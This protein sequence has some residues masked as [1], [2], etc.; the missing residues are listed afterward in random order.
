MLKDFLM[1]CQF[2]GRFPWREKGFRVKEI[3]S[4]WW[5]QLSI[6]KFAICYLQDPLNFAWGWFFLNF[7]YFWRLDILKM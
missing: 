2:L 4:K 1:F 6:A 5:V 3:F 7:L